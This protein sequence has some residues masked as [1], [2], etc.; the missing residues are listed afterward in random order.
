RELSASM[1]N[2][3]RLRLGPLTRFLLRLAGILALLLIVAF[4]W[5]W[6]PPM[7]RVACTTSGKCHR[8]EFS[9]DGSTMATLTTDE[10]EKA[11]LVLWNVASGKKLA[12]RPV[13]W[14]RSRG[15]GSAY[16]HSIVVRL[17]PDGR[18]VVYQEPYADNGGRLLI[19][20]VGTEPVVLPKAWT[21][22][23]LSWP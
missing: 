15:Q 6:L 22:L 16:Q 19:W 20:N 14:D 10:A 5:W 8:L 3:F 11:E 4:L 9:A 17:S 21:V 1:R 13:Q 7:P 23:A 12:S 18:S 2:P